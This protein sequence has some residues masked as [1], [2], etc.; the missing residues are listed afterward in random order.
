MNLDLE[1]EICREK[2]IKSK[3][4]TCKHFVIFS[5][6]QQDKKDLEP[7]LMDIT[8]EQMGYS[9]SMI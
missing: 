1:S 5:G 7:L 6:I 9:L 2:W 4:C 8:E 3:S